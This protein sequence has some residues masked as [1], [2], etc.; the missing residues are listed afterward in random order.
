M[1]TLTK[2][3]VVLVARSFAASAIVQGGIDANDD[4]PSTE[5]VWS[6]LVASMDKMHMGMGAI[7]SSG[8]SD[9]D[10]VRLMLPHHQ[11]AID[12]AKTSF[13]TARI[14]KCGDLHRRSSPTNSS[15]SN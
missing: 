11:A 5:P 4:Q 7:A 9:V 13:C 12:M 3:L 15:K 10:F 2:L 1:K 14:R 8:N 6:D